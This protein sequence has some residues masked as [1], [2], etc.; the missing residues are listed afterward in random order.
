MRK[1]ILLFEEFS[2]LEQLG[3]WPVQTTAQWATS[4]LNPLSCLVDGFSPTNPA[5]TVATGRAGSNPRDLDSRAG[6]VS[7]CRCISESV[8][9]CVCNPPLCLDINHRSPVRLFAL[10]SPATDC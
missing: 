10:T 7:E 9:V 2:K 1:P 4:V 6:P 3:K 8:G 5:Y